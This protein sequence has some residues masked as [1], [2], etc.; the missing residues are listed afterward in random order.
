[1]QPDTGYKRWDGRHTGIWKRRLVIARNCLGGIL[2]NKFLKIFISVAWI[3]GLI[4]TALLFLIGQLLVSDSFIV[5]LV[6]YADED[7]QK[8]VRG[9]MSWLE[10]VPEASVGSTFN[11][12]FYFFCKF[13]FMFTLIAITVSIP[14]LVTRDLSSNAILIYSSKAV[15]RI[16]YLIGKF[17]G[18]FGLMCLT[19]LGPLTM[20]WVLGNF[21]AP[22][23]H[24]FWHARL[25][26]IHAATF[27]VIAM[28]VLAIIAIGIS[29]ISSNSKATVSIWLGAWLLGNALVGLSH[30]ALPW[31]KFLSFRHSL[32]Q[33]ALAIFKLPADVDRVS[34]N[35]PLVGAPLG[36]LQE[37][38]MLDWMQAD[39]LGASISLGVMVA[40]A[41]VIVSRKVTTE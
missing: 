29:S 39:L 30:A 8:V 2:Q 26:L 23:W 4:M 25:A 11:L 27:S 40:L 41:G 21:L 36:E 32:D 1:M 28:A 20:A 33:I 22:K 34:E 38:G 6:G 14:H 35:I 17:A 37:N 13:T 12:L 19:L 7:V 9:F 5:K 3:A 16:D 24:F 15:G 18:I 31:V 10:M